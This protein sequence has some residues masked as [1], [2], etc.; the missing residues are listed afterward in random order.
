MRRVTSLA[1]ILPLTCL[2]SVPAAMAADLP[3]GRAPPV[4][5]PAVAPP[6]FTWSG[7]YVGGQ[8]GTA[9]GADAAGTHIG[10]ASTSTSENG[11]IG[12]AHV[13]YDYATRG[14][15][16]LGNASALA[17]VFGVEGDIDGTSARANTS[18]GAVNGLGG[19]GVTNTPNVEGSVR[20]RLGIAVDRALFYATGGVALGNFSNSYLNAFNGLSDSFN[21]TRVGY[22]VGGGIEYAFTNHLSARVEYRHTDFG[23]SFDN[24]ANST[25]GGVNVH[26]RDV[27]NRVQA[28]FS[29]RFDMFSP[30][31]VVARY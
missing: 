28:G 30:A 18:L 4:Y 6:V 14:L 12:G 16:F 3:S 27:E 11:V 7:F 29:Y 31:P 1:L 23:R 21:S 20:G 26:Q 5:V 2:T 19:I 17:V 25:G 9:F 8:V 13:G 22:T 24:L 15:P 10:L